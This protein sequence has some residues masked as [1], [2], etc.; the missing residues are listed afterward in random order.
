MRFWPSKAPIAQFL[1]ARGLNVNHW[2]ASGAR[3][4]RTPRR[5]RPQVQQFQ[6]SDAGSRRDIGRIF[7]E[8]EGG[9]DS[10]IPEL[11][12]TFAAA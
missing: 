7:G 5:G 1:E 6:R 12:Q 2:I 9:H 8:T 4:A 3:V 11:T 10:T